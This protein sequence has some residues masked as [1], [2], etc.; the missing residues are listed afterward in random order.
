MCGRVYIYVILAWVWRLRPCR[1]YDSLRDVYYSTSLVFHLARRNLNL[2]TAREYTRQRPYYFEMDSFNRQLRLETLLRLLGKTFANERLVQRSL[3]E[4]GA[5][6]VDP[7]PERLFWLNNS[8]T[9]AQLNRTWYDYC[10]LNQPRCVRE[11]ASREY[12]T[13]KTHWCL[14]FR[15]KNHLRLRRDVALNTSEIT[16]NLDRFNRYYGTFYNSKRLNLSED[17]IVQEILDD[18]LAGNMHNQPVYVKNL[19]ESFKQRKYEQRPKVDVDDDVNECESDVNQGQ[20]PCDRNAVCVNTHGSYKCKCKPGYVGLGTHGNCFDGR[21]CSGRFCR[22]HGE[23]VFQ[24]NLNGYKCKCAL[25]CANGGR[26]VIGRYKYECVCP[27][28]VT[29]L[30]CNETVE[31]YLMRQKLLDS[32]RTFN[33]TDSILLS[34][35][36][37]F[38]EPNVDS[39]DVHFLKF[40]NLTNGQQ[41][42][43]DFLN[44]LNQHLT[45]TSSNVSPLDPDFNLQLKQSIEHHRLND[46]LHLLS[47]SHQHDHHLF[48]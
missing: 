43:F 25:N 41:V 38:V 5:N 23:C 48:D 13:Y 40:Y 42:K 28:N 14:S 4:I 45:K 46:I 21:F 24:D 10:E 47:H 2:L 36:V 29:G 6:Y 3:G 8:R 33:S 9:Y 18:L 34:N 1:E 15:V 27:H 26:C 11:C 31:Y 44:L 16:A 22:M 30:N 20:G 32:I 37:K 39:A 19:L 17:L 12:D 35:L 7:S